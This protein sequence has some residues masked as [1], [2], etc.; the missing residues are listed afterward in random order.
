MVSCVNNI[1]SGNVRICLQAYCTFY[2][3]KKHSLNHKPQSTY[4]SFI[5]MKTQ[6]VKNDI[7]MQRKPTAISRILLNLGVDGLCVWSST[8]KPRPP[9]VNRN[10]E[11]RPSMMYW[12]F[13]LYGINAT[14]TYIC[15]SSMV[16]TKQPKQK[17]NK[18]GQ[19]IL[20]FAQQAII[21]NIL[22]T[23]VKILKVNFTFQLEKN[24][25]WRILKAWPIQMSFKF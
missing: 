8:T 23:Y 9:S 1:G 4:G 3:Q 14:Y 20:F 10:D 18:S 19:Q 5:R 6:H 16:N 13:T 7:T 24:V 11:A 22:K 25:T 17:S 15:V 21:R 2:Q 12:P